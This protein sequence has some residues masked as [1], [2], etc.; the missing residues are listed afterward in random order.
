M[1]RRELNA[2]GR[3]QVSIRVMLRGRRAMHRFQDALVLLRPGYRE[4]V[5]MQGGDLL[6]LRTHAASHDHLAIF[7][8]R[9]TDGVERFSLRAIQKAARVNDCEVGISVAARQLITFSAQPR[10]NAL[11]ITK[12]FGQPSETKEMRGAR[13][14]TG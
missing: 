5:R 1:P 7:G 6:R 11:G 12:A 8:K 13:F 2:L 4:H 14:I 9:R 10:D 3:N